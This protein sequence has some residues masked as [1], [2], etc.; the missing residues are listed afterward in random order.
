MP[1]SAA[2]GFS[3]ALFRIDC[4]SDSL[5]TESRARSMLQ[6]K[7]RSEDKIMEIRIDANSSTNAPNGEC[8]DG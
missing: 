2:E 7:I 6:L 3:A 4:Q 1:S 5:E 8:S